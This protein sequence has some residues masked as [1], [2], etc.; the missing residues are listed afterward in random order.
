MGVGLQVEGALDNV[1]QVATGVLQ[2]GF[3]DEDGRADQKDEQHQ[4]HRQHHVQDRQ[5]LYPLVQP[6]HH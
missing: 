2:E 4:R 1:V 3:E 6:G 5:V